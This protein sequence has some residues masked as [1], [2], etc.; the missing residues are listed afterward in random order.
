MMTT[1][2]ASSNNIKDKPR[3]NSLL[4]GIEEE[5]SAEF[6]QELLNLE[7]QDSDDDSISLGLSDAMV[8]D[9]ELRGLQASAA[10]VDR[11][12]HEQEQDEEE[13]QEDFD[14][15]AG[16]ASKRDK[17]LTEKIQKR[18]GRIKLI[19]WGLLLL[20]S[21]VAILTSHFIS[22]GEDCDEKREQVS[23]L[24]ETTGQRN[25][26]HHGLCDASLSTVCLECGLVGAK[27]TRRD[28]G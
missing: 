6:S 10:S 17:S 2:N 21:V 16:S 13:V 24:W 5:Q 11:D 1:G 23:T 19:T 9:D 18:T 22:R 25:L 28:S 15:E 14:E 12:Q 20:W 26:Q 27:C 4:D 7:F 8:G 3:R